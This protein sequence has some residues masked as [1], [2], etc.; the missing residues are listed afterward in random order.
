MHKLFN[1]SKQ[2]L[3][4][5][6]D[7]LSEDDI[8]DCCSPT[9]YQRG[10]DYYDADDVYQATYNKE[11]TLLKA[12]VSGNKEYAI[13]IS[14][15]NG[16]VS[17]SCTCPYDG[18]CKHLVA[19]LLFASDMFEIEI[20]ENESKEAGDNFQQYLQT[21]SKDELMALVEKFAPDR[22]RTEVKNK[23]TDPGSAQQVFRK[24]EQ[25][26]RRLFEND[27]LM[28]SFSDFN[29]AID[30]EL[31]KLSG[32]EKPLQKELEKFLFELMQK[33]ET[34]EENGEL[35]EYDNDWG[36]A[37]SAFFNEFF[38]G[39]VASLDNVQKTAF[40]AKLDAALQEQSYS[41]FEGL[42]DA[43]NSAF[44]DDD[45]PHLKNTLAA[46][47][48]NLSQ[49]LTG[50]YYDRVH[51]LLSYKEKTAILSVLSEQNSKRMIE[52]ATLYDAGGELSK[53]IETLKNRFA[54]NRDFFS[55]DE[56]VHSLYLDF[57]QKGNHELSEVAAEIIVRCPTQTML[58]KIISLTGDDP[59]RYE[60]LLEQKNNVELLRYL[61]NNNRLHEAL[62]LV[63]RRP[64]MSDSSVNDFFKAHKSLFPDD[65]A[66]YFSKVIEKN[67]QS[68]GDRYYEA[69][70]DAIRHMMKV[71]PSKANE[72][73]NH[74]RTTY[75]RRSNL[76][77]MLNKL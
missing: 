61:Q 7:S 42:R 19:A 35:Y 68:T 16:S 23:F 69:I 36:Y 76:M 56:D 38:A 27:R 58:T 52:L 64:G 40:L 29:D 66:A 60:L 49:K 50:I 15:G 32:L 21:L 44:S 55:Y 28:Q 39:F 51:H 46:E 62:A 9:I 34:A 5:F 10:A 25:K 4:D 57:L 54:A 41:T 71:N 11:K 53:A 13:T 45:L 37:P 43:A 18:V 6:F 31:A 12:I 65:A 75:K 74:I 17:G 14:L 3:S 24:V 33:I 72:Y 1:T 48:Q 22:F 59:A 67:L 8:Q 73:L 47:Y 20:E 63:N 77:A 26:I 70:T 30:S 2:S